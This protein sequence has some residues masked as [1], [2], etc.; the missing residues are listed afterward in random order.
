M[1]TRIT[2]RAR[3]ERGVTLATARPARAPK[4]LYA[5]D[6]DGARLDSTQHVIGARYHPTTS[7]HPALTLHG[8][9][10]GL[11]TP[12]PPRPGICHR[13]YPRGTAGTRANMRHGHER[14]FALSHCA[15]G[16]RTPATKPF[17]PYRPS[18]PECRCAGIPGRLARADGGTS[19]GERLTATPPG[20]RPARPP[21]ASRPGRRRS[22]AP[23]GPAPPSPPTSPWTRRR[24]AS[25]SPAG[26]SR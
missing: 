24:R 15:A 9:S 17:A 16:S 13:P 12:R 25:G 3:V 20:S 19:S 6:L 1:Q 26:S 7:A 4:R 21:T 11:R 14:V 5:F 8:P 22:G 18:S 2:P 23:P 10:A